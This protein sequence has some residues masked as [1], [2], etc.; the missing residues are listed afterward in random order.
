MARNVSRGNAYAP[1]RKK[2]VRVTSWNARV[3]PIATEKRIPT[4]S[5]SAGRVP[6]QARWHDRDLVDINNGLSGGWSSPTP[7]RRRR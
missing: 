4:V 6:N 7:H 2:V 5:G 3:R 1:D